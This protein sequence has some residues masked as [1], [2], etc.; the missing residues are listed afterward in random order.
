MSWH[1]RSPLFWIACVFVLR[2]RGS[3]QI[4]ELLL[5]L[6]CR[7]IDDLLFQTENVG[8]QYLLAAFSSLLR[9]RVLKVHATYLTKH[10]DQLL[11]ILHRH[12]AQGLVHLV[13]VPGL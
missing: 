8:L 4:L 3:F 2:S 6:L 7:S 13:Q 5:P 12:L 1:L 10:V 11:R 9:P